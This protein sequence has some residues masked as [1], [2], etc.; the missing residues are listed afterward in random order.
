M[1]LLHKKGFHEISLH[2]S[3][4]QPATSF[5]EYIKS[6]GQ[7]LLFYSGRVFKENFHTN[8]RK[9]V[10][11]QFCKFL[12]ETVLIDIGITASAPLYNLSLWRIEALLYVHKHTLFGSII[13]NF[14]SPNVFTGYAISGQQI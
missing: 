6:P 8:T 14:S 10:D 11:V 4:E 2:M 5:G 3:Y 13:A 7:H 12:E 9:D 1:L